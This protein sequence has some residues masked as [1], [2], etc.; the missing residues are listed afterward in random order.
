MGGPRKFQVLKNDP[1][2]AATER[3]HPPQSYRTLLLGVVALGITWRLTRYLLRMPLW[4][5]EAS[6]AVNFLDRGYRQLLEPLAVAQVSPI[7][8]LWGELT[9]LKIAGTSELALR[10]LPVAAGIASLLLFWPLAKLAFDGLPEGHVAAA[11]AISILAVSYYPVRHASEVKP[12]SCDLLAAVCLLLLGLKWLVDPE[13]RLPKILLIVLLPVA[14]GISFP[15]AFVAGGIFIALVP[16]AFRRGISRQ[17]A[18]LIAYAAVM[19]A[20]FVTLYKLSDVTQFQANA[21]RLTTYWKGSFPP[22]GLWSLFVWFLDIHTSNLMAYPIGGKHMGSIVTTL[23]FAIGSAYLLKVRHY[24]LLT[25]LLAPFAMTFVAACLHRYPYGGSARVAQHLAPAICLLSG[26][27]IVVTLRLL[28]PLTSSY[29]IGLRS[30]WVL[31][32][33]IAIGGIA[34]ELGHPYKSIGDVRVREIANG[35]FSHPASIVTVL[36]AQ[37]RV[38]SDFQWYLGRHGSAVS[39]SGRIDAD[40]LRQQDVRL[41][42]VDFEP[43]PDTQQ[44]VAELMDHAGLDCRLVKSESETMLI[45]PVELPPTHLQIFEW[46]PQRDSVHHAP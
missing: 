8:F 46:M 13:P 2:E 32:G 38:P 42:F 28:L 4:G 35:I 15:A 23:F 5:D 25:I 24:S 6:L 20:S 19:G 43:Q 1:G 30:V 16:G 3:V 31:L 40:R 18:W 11:L 12:Y 22:A 41:W 34:R 29:Q 9:V 37:D 44:R 17:A 36:N 21:T 26:I 45:G 14:L 33:A 7:L 39:W 10:F 27:G